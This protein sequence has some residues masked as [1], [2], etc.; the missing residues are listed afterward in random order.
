MERLIETAMRQMAKAAH[1][2]L[3]AHGL[4]ANDDALAEE[5]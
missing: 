1:A 5:G 2:Y 4:K 3:D